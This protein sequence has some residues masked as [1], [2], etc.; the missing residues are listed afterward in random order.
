MEL[1][2]QKEKVAAGF[3]LRRHRLESLCHPKIS[4]WMERFFCFRKGLD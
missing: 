3:S 1:G 2:N 4:S